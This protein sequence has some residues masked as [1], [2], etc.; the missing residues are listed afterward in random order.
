[1]IST[2]LS[3]QCLDSFNETNLVPVHGDIMA[4]NGN[5]TS[6]QFLG[7]TLVQEHHFYMKIQACSCVFFLVTF[8][9]VSLVL[10]IKKGQAFSCHPSEQ[11]NSKEHLSWTSAVCQSLQYTKIQVCYRVPLHNAGDCGINIVKGN[12]VITVCSDNCGKIFLCR[13]RLIMFSETISILFYFYGLLFTF[14]LLA[15]Y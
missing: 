13:P 15:S 1:M 6:C 12:T 8:Y 7:N 4:F 11:S 10:H 2:A 9:I 5:L 3:S 14:N